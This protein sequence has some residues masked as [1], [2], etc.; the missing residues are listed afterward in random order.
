MRHWAIALA[1]TGLM[2]LPGVSRAQSA[3]LFETAHLA[4]VEAG[5]SLDYDVHAIRTE[6]P[7]GGINGGITDIAGEI[8]LAATAGSAP[9]KR[10]IEAVLTRDGRSRTLPP[11]Q[12]VKGNPV[13][14]IFLEQV[15]QDLSQATGGSGTYLRNR[16]REGLAKGLTEETVEGGTAL[17]M[18]PLEGDANQQALGPYA[19]LEL[20]FVIDPDLPGMIRSMSASVGPADAPVFVEEVSYDAPDE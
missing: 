15:L 13:V 7:D 1:V 20:R 3:L 9:D 18:R 11:F 10:N 19:G 4:G 16:L 17:V 14:V 8:V 6:T 5:S 2:A 12:G